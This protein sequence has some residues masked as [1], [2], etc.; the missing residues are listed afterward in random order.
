MQPLANWL[1][2]LPQEN[3][4]DN[5]KLHIVFI[6]LIVCWHTSFLALLMNSNVNQLRINFTE[7]S[8]KLSPFAAVSEQL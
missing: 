7:G 2:Q 5:L 8:K 1:G 6:I 4:I 3:I